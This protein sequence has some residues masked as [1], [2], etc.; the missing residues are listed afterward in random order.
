MKLIKDLGMLY[1][2]NNSK[3]KRRFGLY[4]C[5]QCHKEVMVQTTSI[6]AGKSS[7]CYDCGHNTHR[8]TAHP[9]FSTWANIRARCYNHNVKAY[10][11]YG[12]LGIVLSEEF[13]EPQAFFDYIESLENFGKDGY[14]LDRIAVDG[15]YERGN[16]RWASRSTQRQNTRLIMS[17]NKSGYRGVCWHKTNNKWVARITYDSKRV[18]LGYFIDKKEAAKAYDAFV[19]AHDTEYPLNFPETSL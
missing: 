9:L 2:R 11:N 17:T 7:K 4:E 15:D 6:K 10:Q 13:K 5:P 1:P 12:N 18:H 16:L 14:T 3:Q 8:S 19:L